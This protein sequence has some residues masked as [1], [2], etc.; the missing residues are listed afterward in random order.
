MADIPDI[1]FHFHQKLICCFRQF[2]N[3]EYP[4][5]ADSES[6]SLLILSATEFLLFYAIP[7]EVPLVVS[8]PSYNPDGTTQTDTYNIAAYVAKLLWIF[9]EKKFSAYF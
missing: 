7:E 4:I 6:H 5:P 3:T 9:P 8:G 2:Q 1:L